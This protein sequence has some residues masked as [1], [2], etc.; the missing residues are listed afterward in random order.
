MHALEGQVQLLIHQ[1]QLQAWQQQTSRELKYHCLE[2]GW[3]MA[4]IFRRKEQMMITTIR[5]IYAHD[6][7]HTKYQGQYFSVNLG[8]GGG[9]A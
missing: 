1:Q 9:H 5:L 3:E 6:A 7:S 2:I 4:P 8:G